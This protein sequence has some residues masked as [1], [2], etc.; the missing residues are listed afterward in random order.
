MRRK[1]IPFSEAMAEI[2]ARTDALARLMPRPRKPLKGI[3]ARSEEEQYALCRAV[4]LTVKRN[5]EAG[6]IVR[7]PDGSFVIDWTKDP[8]LKKD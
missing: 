1:P 3:S 6:F 2:K 5:Q 8:N 7:Q 4:V